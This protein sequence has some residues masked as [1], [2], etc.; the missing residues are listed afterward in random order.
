MLNL[1]VMFKGNEVSGN[2][3]QVYIYH[4]IYNYKQI[5]QCNKIFSVLGLPKTKDWNELSQCE[6]YSNIQSWSS[7]E[8]PFPPSSILREK[9]NN[10]NDDKLEDLL[11]RMLEFNPENR[12][13][14][15]D[16]I[17]HPFF[18]DLTLDVNATNIF[19]GYEEN[20]NIQIGIYQNLML[21]FIF[22]C[23][24]HQILFN[25]FKNSIY[26]FLF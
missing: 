9:V 10:H 1:E 17:K 20:I 22:T 13:N 18:D 6:Y 11:S 23:F 26:L 21:I 15:E 25:S 4:F 12:I 19:S 16:A 24:F 14:A 7:S 8:N 2:A 3:F 5:E